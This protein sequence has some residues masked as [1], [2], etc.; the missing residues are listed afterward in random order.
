VDWKSWLKQKTT[1]AGFSSL[2]GTATAW[3]T[4]QISGKQAISLGVFGVIMVLWPEEK[5][6]TQS[7]VGTIVGIVAKGVGQL[8]TPAPTP[9]APV[10]AVITDEVKK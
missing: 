7:D 8:D 4:G 9:V 3:A 6:L 2:A 10:P 5:V 1:G